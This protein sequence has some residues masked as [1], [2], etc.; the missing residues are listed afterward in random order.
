MYKEF[1]ESW[2]EESFNDLRDSQHIWVNNKIKTEEN[3]Q[4]DELLKYQTLIKMTL[5]RCEE[6]TKYYK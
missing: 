1:K 2:S 6:W 5:D 3:M 4:G